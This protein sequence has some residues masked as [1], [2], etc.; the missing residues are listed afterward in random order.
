[1]I[2]GAAILLVVMQHVGGGLDLGLSFLCKVD[3]PLFFVV[4]GFLAMK[5][6]INVRQEIV[7][8]TRRILLPLAVALPFA[9][10]WHGL[11]LMEAVT[12]IGKCGYWFL[13]CLWLFFLLFYAICQ[14][15]LRGGV[16]APCA[17]EILLLGLSKYSPDMIDNVWG[18][19]YMSRYFPCFMAG[20]Y[21][22]RY[23]IKDLNRVAGSLML[24]STC[25]AF[26][27]EW[28]NSN[29]SFLLC[30]MGYLCAAL[31]LFYFLRDEAKEMPGLMKRFLIMAGRHSLSIYIIHFYFVAQFSTPTGHFAI[32]FAKVV[33]LSVLIVLLSVA[34]EKILVKVTLLNKIL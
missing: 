2:R 25:V 9:A 13:L 31:P 1:M 27:M 10:F 3:V 14:L 12:D 26:L 15:N 34:L 29:V 17:I 20:V 33:S 6:T 22:R 11:S 5:P 16:F 7:K 8:K 28:H 21:I 24:A 19:S 18:I 32:D 30:V 23:G 4:S